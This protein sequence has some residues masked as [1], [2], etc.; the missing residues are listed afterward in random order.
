MIHEEVIHYHARMSKEIV[1][2][3][4]ITCLRLEIAVTLEI[5]FVNLSSTYN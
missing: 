2:Q 1:M 5:N 3:K 4:G